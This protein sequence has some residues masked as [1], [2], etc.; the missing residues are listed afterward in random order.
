MYTLRPATHDD[1]HFL[2]HLHISTI[3]PA[4]EA[5]WGWD[6]AFQREYFREHFDPATRQIIEIGR[7]HV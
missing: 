4:V 7:A 5:T 2:Y 3:R 1:Y 6:E